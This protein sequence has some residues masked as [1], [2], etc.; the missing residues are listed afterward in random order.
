MCPLKTPLL[1]VPGQWP[2][3][4]VSPSRIPESETPRPASRLHAI[5]RPNVLLCS[6]H[7][8]LYSYVRRLTLLALLSRLCSFLHPHVEAHKVFAFCEWKL[9]LAARTTFLRPPPAL[10]SG[11]RVFRTAKEL[12]W[13][14]TTTTVDRSLTTTITTRLLPVARRH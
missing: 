9:R 2:H 10:N 6:L 1:S 13:Q 12:P 4:R 8:L 3:T 7:L 11:P 14:L 5:G